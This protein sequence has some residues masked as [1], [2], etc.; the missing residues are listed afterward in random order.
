MVGVKH[1]ILG[2]FLFSVSLVFLRAQEKEE[3]LP[4]EPQ[5]LY[6]FPVGGQ[7]GSTVEVIIDG[8][9]LADSYAVWTD[10]PALQASVKQVVETDREI[11]EVN[12]LPGEAVDPRG[13]S[14]SKDLPGGCIG[15]GILFGWFR[16]A[17]SPTLCP[18]E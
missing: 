5:A 10:C 1:V 8:Q 17:A 15:R 12:Y 4:T 18:F 13:H 11:W 14:A 3:P 9:T 7:Q 2:A 16:L 6:I